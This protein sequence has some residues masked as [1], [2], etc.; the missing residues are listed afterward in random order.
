LVFHLV[1]NT[2]QDN[3]ILFFELIKRD[4]YPERRSPVLS[5]ERKRGK[6]KQGI[7]YGYWPVSLFLQDVPPEEIRQPHAPIM[8][9]PHVTISISMPK[10][11]TTRF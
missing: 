1:S 7:Y 9:S 10:R 11:L 8:N 4:N 2:R 5:R 3:K 6:K